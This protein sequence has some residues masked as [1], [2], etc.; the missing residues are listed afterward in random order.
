MPEGVVR[1]L[2]QYIAIIDENNKGIGM[3]RCVMYLE[4]MG[5]VNDGNLAS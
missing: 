3:L 1:V 2:D 5:E 4:D